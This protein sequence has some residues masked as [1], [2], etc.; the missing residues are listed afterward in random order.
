MTSTAL[1]TSPPRSGAGVVVLSAGHRRAPE[2]PADAGRDRSAAGHP[3]PVTGR[4][5]AG[6]PAPEGP[7]VLVVDDAPAIRSALRG[8]LEDAGIAVVGEA[9][10]GV[11]GVAMAGELRP[12]VVIMDL[13]MPS[14]DGFQATERI[15]EA[16]PDVSVVVL[17]AYE[18]RESAAAVRAAG[19]YA[20]LPKDCAADRI[21]ET[22]LAAWRSRGRGAPGR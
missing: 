13:R 20:F 1:G 5:A 15:A 21:R 19:A 18:S 6:T 17:S 9:N 10:D 8:L 3:T 7:R 11:Q 16:F 2:E 4:A 12:D 14:S 22:V